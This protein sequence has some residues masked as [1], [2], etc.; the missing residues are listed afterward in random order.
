[1]GNTAELDKDLADGLKAAKTKRCYFA[2]V[3][4]G[5][6]DGALLVSK[7]K[8]P[9]PAIAEAKKKSGGSAVVSGFVSYEDG[10]YVFET[11]KPPAGTAAAAV[12][13][14]AKRDAGQTIKAIFRQS[15]DPELLA[16]DGSPEATP[17]TGTTK[18]TEPQAT[19][20]TSALGPLPEAAKYATALQDW[21]QAAAAALSATDKLTATLEATG[22]E[23]AL[24]IV[25]IIDKLKADFPDTLDDVLTNLAKTAKDGKAADAE[26]WRNKSEIAIKAALAYLG[27]NA[28]TID[29]CEKNPFGIS[30]PFRAALTEALK[31]VLIN[32]KK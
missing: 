6:T 11:A 31:K 18:T 1:M 10:T 25:E 17:A 9:A 19:P 24:A 30:V 2:L 13:T 23:L 4:K 21:Q 8:V 16:L 14:I 26:G 15:T 32:V 29:A 28:A 20:K 22:D 3:L 7:T 27:N 5:G 12:K